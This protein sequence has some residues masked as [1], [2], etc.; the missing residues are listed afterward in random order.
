MKPKTIAT[1]HW[2]FAL[3][4]AAFMLFG[5]ISEVI[6]HPSGQEIMRHL[7]YPEHVLT[8]LGIGKLLG[9][10]ALLQPWHRT[11]KEWA[12][13]GFTFNLL[14]ASVA[15]SAAHDGFWLVAS[16][17]LFLGFMLISYALWRRLLAQQH[18]Q[19][20]ENQYSQCLITVSA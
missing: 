20:A 3:P 8:V 16:P 17:L 6:H 2:S 18:Q 5:G 10:A 9:A 4:F 11:L 12:Y 1:L 19:E 7:G 13:A 14:G 15:R